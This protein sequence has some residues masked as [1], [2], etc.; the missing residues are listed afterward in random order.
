MSVE[1]HRSELAIALD[2]SNHAR[3]MPPILPT[4]HKRILDVGCGM[5]QT[6]LA[7]QLPRWIAT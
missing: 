4:K 7:A 1:Y 3:A 2:P 5:G 6:L